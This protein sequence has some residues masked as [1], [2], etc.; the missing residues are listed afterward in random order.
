MSTPQPRAIDRLNQAY[1]S[2]P[3]DTRQRRRLAATYK[4]NPRMDMM[5]S[6]KE[7][8]PELWQHLDATTRLSIA[9]YL[10]AKRAY[11]AEQAAAAVLEAQ[12]TLDTLYQQYAAGEHVRV[13]DVDRARQALEAAR[14][15]QAA[16]EGQ[17]A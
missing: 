12:A 17:S 13:A 16:L 8:K 2:A 7:T 14:G 4:P 6:W 11:E 5:A 10:E 1:A 15:M 9:H 3:P